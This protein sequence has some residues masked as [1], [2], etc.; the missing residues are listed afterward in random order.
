MR[1]VTCPHWNTSD[2]VV[3]PLGY[4]YNSGHLYP[5]PTSC[6]SSSKWSLTSQ[7]ADYLAVYVTAPENVTPLPSAASVKRIAYPHLIFVVA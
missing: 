4:L 6:S 5:H 3:I 1:N 2:Q 7:L